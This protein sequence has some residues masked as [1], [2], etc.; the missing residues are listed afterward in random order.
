MLTWGE[1]KR[2]VDRQLADGSGDGELV[3]FID[4]NGLDQPKVDFRVDRGA[5]GTVV[6]VL[7]A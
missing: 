6:Y 3:K 5:G 2:I 4:W 7:V 1:F